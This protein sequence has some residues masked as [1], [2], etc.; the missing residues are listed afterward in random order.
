MPWKIVWNFINGI[1]APMH[2]HT[3]PMTGGPSP[4]I[5]SANHKRFF[6]FAFHHQLAITTCAIAVSLGYICS[7]SCMR[8]RVRLHF[9]FSREWAV[10]AFVSSHFDC[11]VFAVRHI[12]QYATFTRTH[13]Q[14]PAQSSPPCSGFQFVCVI[15]CASTDTSSSQAWWVLHLF[16]AFV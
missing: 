8:A 15:E 3:Q 5:K 7:L 16:A 4:W 1:S 9:C 11:I 12:R 2:R 6:L 14:T 13:S 10:N